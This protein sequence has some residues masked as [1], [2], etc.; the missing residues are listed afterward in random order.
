[1]T[2]KQDKGVDA[3]IEKR[4]TVFV[5][6]DMVLDIYAI[7][8]KEKDEEKRQDLLTKAFYLSKN[9]NTHLPLKKSQY[10]V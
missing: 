3:T 1:M 8:L 4:H 5:T 7:Y 6:A 9:L 10:Q 2:S